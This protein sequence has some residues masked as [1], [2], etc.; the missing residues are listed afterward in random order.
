MYKITEQFLMLGKPDKL[1]FL[2]FCLSEVN[3][4]HGKTHFNKHMDF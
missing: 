4:L 3:K 2:V 1:L